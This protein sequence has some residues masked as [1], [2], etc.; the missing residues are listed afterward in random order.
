MDV[1]DIVERARLAVVGGE[2]S[3]WHC[4]RSRE[5][6]EKRKRL[7]AFEKSKEEYRA[8]RRK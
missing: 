1:K 7:E 8:K 5:M 6:H 2:I 3:G 4:A